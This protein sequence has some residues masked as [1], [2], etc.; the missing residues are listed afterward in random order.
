[1]VP[2]TTLWACRCTALSHACFSAKF[3]P[4]FTALALIRA[5]QTEP[6]AWLPL[7][8]AP[9][10]VGGG[11]EVRS[12]KTLMRTTR[13]IGTGCRV[14]AAAHAC[15]TRV[16]LKIDRASGPRSSVQYKECATAS[17][18]NATQVISVIFFRLRLLINC[19]RDNKW[20][21]RKLVMSRVNRNFFQ[22][23]HAHWRHESIFLAECYSTWAIAVI[24]LQPSIDRHAS[25]HAC[26][27]D[28]LSVHSHRNS[29]SC[30]VR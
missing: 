1:M 24:N 22:N 16:Q 21:K 4:A 3:E 7:S 5:W 6:C 27:Q 13:E 15:Y 29:G 2:L 25:Y 28:P 17:I 10:R 14:L 26:G 11:H 12:P 30:L 8:W 19:S 23:A 20:Y 18:L 9:P